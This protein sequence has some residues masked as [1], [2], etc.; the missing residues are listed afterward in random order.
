VTGP[1]PREEAARGAGRRAAPPLRAVEEP[2]EGRAVPGG[3][4]YRFAGFEGRGGRLLARFTGPGPDFLVPPEGPTW[5]PAC[6]AE[7]PPADPALAAELAAAAAEWL[8]LARTL[9]VVRG[10]D[11]PHDR[12]RWAR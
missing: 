7:E 3:G 1:T 12:R 8:A 2:P 10:H 5:P 9:H 6:E 11:R 4:R